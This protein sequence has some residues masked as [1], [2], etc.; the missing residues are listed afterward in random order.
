MIVEPA[1]SSRAMANSLFDKYVA[2][3]QAGFDEDE[4]FTLTET[5]MK[6]ALEIGRRQ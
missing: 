5:Y 3:M 2:F 4:A 6:M 1:A